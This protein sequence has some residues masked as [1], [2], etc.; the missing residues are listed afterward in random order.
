MKMNQAVLVLV[1]ACMAIP[2]F[3]EGVAQDKVGYVDVQKAVQLTSAGKAAKATLDGEFQKR[4]VSL[5]KKKAEIEKMGQELEKKKT[6]LSQD[7]LAK[8][9]TEIQQEMMKFQKTVG[10]NQVEIQKKQ[11]ALVAPILAK[12]Q[13]AVE[14]V[15]KEKGY[16]MIIDKKEQNVLFSVAEADLTDAVVKAFEKEK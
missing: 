7:V 13:K 5:D 8:K 11:E 4:K 1:A 15:A 14:T 6:A 9:Q 10:E 3:A 2:A 12:M 16:A